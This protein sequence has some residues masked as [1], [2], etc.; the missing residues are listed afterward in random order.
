MMAYTLCDGKLVSVSPMYIIVISVLVLSFITGLI[1]TIMDYSKRKRESISNT[2]VSNDV[3]KTPTVTSNNIKETNMH[4]NI[5]NNNIPIINMNTPNPINTNINSNVNNNVA[6]VIN[7]IDDNN[8]NQKINP[9]D[10]L[11]I[12]PNDIETLDFEPDIKII[13]S[14]IDKLEDETDIK[15]TYMD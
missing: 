9:I 13:P 5:N 4:N 7:N 2:N 8:T 10:T 3:K 12:I 6:V 11:K 1:I 15:I 14:D